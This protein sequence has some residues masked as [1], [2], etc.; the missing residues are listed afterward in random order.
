MYVRR[1]K[2]SGHITTQSHSWTGRPCHVVCCDG[3]AA[4]SSDS[5]V[6][7]LVSQ[8]SRKP[9]TKA[10]FAPARDLLG[11]LRRLPI[12][13]QLAVAKHPYARTRSARYKLLRRNWGDTQKYVIWLLISQTPTINWE[14]N[15]IST[16]FADGHQ[17]REYIDYAEGLV[18]PRWEFVYK[19]GASFVDEFVRV[20]QWIQPK[21]AFHF[22]PAC[23]CMNKGLA[24]FEKIGRHAF[25]L[26][27]YSSLEC[28]TMPP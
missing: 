11:T 24:S 13:A 27:N 14:D 23:S 22:A 1:Q 15:I 8:L 2:Q 25:Q 9:W 21:D 12:G 19:N 4:V 10:E 17:I 18:L 5:F 26:W 6:N 28:R 20:P 7:G 16:P 3:C